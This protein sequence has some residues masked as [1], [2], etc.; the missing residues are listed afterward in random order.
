M[1]APKR[2]VVATLAGWAMSFLA[3][4][5]VL[6]VL[7]ISA[8]LIGASVEDWVRDHPISSITIVLILGC[9]AVS[10]VCLRKLQRVTVESSIGLWSLSLVAASV[11]LAAL[12]YWSGGDVAVLLIGIAEVAAVLLHFVAIGFLWIRKLQ[13]TLL[14]TE[15]NAGHK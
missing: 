2:S 6:S 15:Q 3:S 11:P 5:F 14:A 8:F 1:Q 7:V 12:M 4:S 13:P 10:F 9:Y